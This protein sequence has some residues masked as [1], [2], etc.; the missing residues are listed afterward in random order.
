MRIV[1]PSTRPSCDAP[2]NIKA[3]L[4]SPLFTNSEIVLMFPHI[5]EPLS[6]WSSSSIYH[7]PFRG[8]VYHRFN[9]SFELTLPFQLH[10]SPSN[11]NVFHL[12]CTYNF[13]GVF[14]SFY[15]VLYPGL[16][17]VPYF[18]NVGKFQHFELILPFRLHLS[19]TS[20]TFSTAVLDSLRRS[21]NDDL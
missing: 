6:P 15:K 2:G 1:D 13:H 18:I 5:Y 3:S 8:S 20:K 17:S 11:E 10:L 12:R 14:A 4:L 19:P 7:G 16:V 9:I 21:F